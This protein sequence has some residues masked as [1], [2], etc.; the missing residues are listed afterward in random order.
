MKPIL[1]GMLS[2]VLSLGGTTLVL[3]KLAPHPDPAPTAQAT[4]STSAGKPGTKDSTAQAPADSSAPG[5]DSTAGKDSSGTLVATKTGDN[6]PGPTGAKPVVASH[7]AVDPLAKSAAIKQVARV[8]SAMKAAEAAKVLAFL[9]DAEVEGILRAVGPRQAAD[10]M[11]NLPKERAA[12]LSR[13]LMTPKGPEPS[14]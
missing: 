3:V 12:N 5:R 2:F 14:R 13:R 11:T 8:L 9:S 1:F 7:P 4:D 10:F 6:G